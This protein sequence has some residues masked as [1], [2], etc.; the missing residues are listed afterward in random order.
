MGTVIVNRALA[1]SPMGLDEIAIDQQ[2]GYPPL[3]VIPPEPDLCLRAQ[4][5][6]APLVTFF[7]ESLMAENLI[8]LAAKLEPAGKV[9]A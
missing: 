8:A 6:H 4:T 2:L 9:A 3:A 1:T 5:A 7:P